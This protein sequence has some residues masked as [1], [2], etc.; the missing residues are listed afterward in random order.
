MVN[1]L[2][3]EIDGESFET[4]KSVDI[5]TDLDTFGFAFHISINIPIEKVDTITSRIVSLFKDDKPSFNTQ[6]A[7]VKIKID[8]E[9]ILTGFIEKQEVDFSRDN[10]NLVIS[11]R[12]KLGDFVDS[13]VP[14]TIFKPPIG[15]VDILEK[16]LIATGYEVASPKKSLLS[17]GSKLAGLV[18]ELGSGQVKIVNDYEVNGQVIE[19]FATNESIGF[20][21]DESAYQLIRRLA[22][23]RRLVI[24]TNGDGN[25]VIRSIG[26]ERAGT[27]LV[28]DIFANKLNLDNNIISASIIRDDSRRYYEYKILSRSNSTTVTNAIGVSQSQITGDSLKDN[29]TQYSGIFYDSEIRPTRKFLDNVS[30]LNVSQCKKRAEWECNIRRAKAF[31]YEC[32]VYGWRQN[33]KEIGSLGFSG[34]PLWKIN[35]IV[36]VKDSRAGLLNADLL[37]KSIRYKQSVSIGTIC[38]MTLINPKSYTDSV[39]EMRIKAP[40]RP[41]AQSMDFSLIK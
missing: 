11:G 39:F 31:R 3:V 19:K 4:F 33:L 32:S 36:S 40:K 16:L 2:T 14:N 15:F 10:V 26:Q 12:D 13:R 23:K 7:S 22:D 38:N 17:I 35:Q 21:K 30:N 6:G 28:N 9:A 1:K 37:I 8:G 18:N 41:K 24:G 27:I 25:I 29:T 5:D 34:N 20:G